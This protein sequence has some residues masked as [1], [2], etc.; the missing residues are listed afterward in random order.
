M[1]GVTLT[2]TYAMHSSQPPR[3]RREAAERRCWIKRIRGPDQAAFLLRPVYYVAPPIDARDK[4]SGKEARR[5]QNTAVTR[6]AARTLLPAVSSVLLLFLA[7]YTKPSATLR[8][9]Y[10]LVVQ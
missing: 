1:P 8:V 3:S 7:T 10:I 2:K 4:V 9:S 6:L 5:R